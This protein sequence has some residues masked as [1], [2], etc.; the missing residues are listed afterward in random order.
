MASLLNEEEKAAVQKDDFYATTYGGFADKEDDDDFAYKSPGEEDDRVDSDFSIDE[1]D[2]VKS[3]A[4]DDDKKKKAK[5]ALGVQ[6]KAYKEPKRDS[7]GAIRKKMEKES[8]LV[9]D[10]LAAK[11]RARQEKAAS[12]ALAASFDFGRKQARDSPM[13]KNFS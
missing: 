2:E 8:K 13:F 7:T 12:A 4:D 9:R 6:T 5:R 1:N 10:R 3:D 11:A